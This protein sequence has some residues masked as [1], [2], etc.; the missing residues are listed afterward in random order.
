MY[1][2]LIFLEE[3]KKRSTEEVIEDTAA[4]Y[5]GIFKKRDGTDMTATEIKAA[6]KR[7]WGGYGG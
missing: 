2:N 5:D 4:G 7:W 3:R 6:A 1:T